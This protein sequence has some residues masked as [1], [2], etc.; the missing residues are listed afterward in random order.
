MGGE[1]ADRPRLALQTPESPAAL[2]DPAVR[3]ELEGRDV[4]LHIGDGTGGFEPE[5]GRITA[6]VNRDPRLMPTC[7][8]RTPCL[9]IRLRN[10]SGSS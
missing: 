5:A 6:R 4:G 3:A 2:L 9:A 7:E 1:R 10:I 8:N